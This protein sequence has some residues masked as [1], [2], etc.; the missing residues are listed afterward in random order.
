[1]KGISLYTML[2]LFS[3]TV[4]AQQPE[5]SPGHEDWEY[6]LEYTGDFFQFALPAAA[7]TLTIIEKDKTG[8]KKLLYSYATTL[9]LTY[10]LKDAVGKERP[11]GRGSF[12]SFPSGHTSSAFSGA[13]FIQRRYGWK[14][15]LPAYLMAGVTGVS[16]V[17]GPD[18]FHD[19]WDVLGGAAIGIGSVYLFTKPFEEKSEKVSLGFG[20]DKDKMVFTL[21]Y[22]F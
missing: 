6:A 11:E 2:V 20:Y 13:A 18:G 8:R 1:M 19:F 9:V 12:D 7:L 21:N 22:S 3:G 16:R 17:E 5:E 15:G 10:I 4:V 14:Y